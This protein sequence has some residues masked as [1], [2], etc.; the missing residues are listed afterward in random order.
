MVTENIPFKSYQ[1]QKFVI[2]KQEFFTVVK[3]S[4]FIATDSQ[5]NIEQLLNNRIQNESTFKKIFS[6]NNHNL[7]T[8]IPV[9][10]IKP[11][12]LS[13]KPA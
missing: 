2:D 9:K 8:I 6:L 1:Y 5:K 7:T 12:V 3:D 10:K 11:S 4:I 13:A